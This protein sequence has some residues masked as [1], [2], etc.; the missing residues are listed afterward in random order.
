MAYVLMFM[1]HRTRLI[2]GIFTFVAMTFA[3][4]EAVWASTCLPGMDMPTAAA[5]A[6]PAS[7]LDDCVHGSHDGGGGEN[8]DRDE[9]HCPFGS[10]AAAQACAGL[11]LLPTHGTGSSGPGPDAPSSV[12]V[13]LAGSDLLLSAALFHPPRA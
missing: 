13:E 3:I 10:V 9:R 11:A 1:K 8:K 5:V 4:A 2:A 7:P 6:E 12:F